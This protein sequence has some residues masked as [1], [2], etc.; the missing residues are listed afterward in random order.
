VKCSTNSIGI[1]Y[2][3]A[4]EV[5]DSVSS[6][7]AEGI[8]SQHRARAIVAVAI[9]VAMGS[10]GGLL[11]ADRPAAKTKAI[12]AAGQLQTASPAELIGRALAKRVE[13]QYRHLPLGKVAEDLQAR[14]GVPVVLD[15]RAIKD[16]GIGFDTPITFASSNV[17]TKAAIALMLRPLN[18]QAAVQHEVLL[19]TT[20]EEAETVIDV[21]VYEVSDLVCVDPSDSSQAEFDSLIDVITG[22][23]RPTSWPGS[24]PGPISTFAARGV[25]AIVVAQTQDVHEEIDL[26]LW[27]LRAARNASTKDRERA[28]RPKAKSLEGR[29]PSH[30]NVTE[31]TLLRTLRAEAAIR[32]SLAKPVQL[33]YAAMPLES[34]VDDLQVKV[35]IPIRLDRKALDDI[36]VGLDAPVTF[37]ASNISAKAAIALILRQLHLTA[38]TRYEVLLVT[39]PVEAATML[40][41]RVY[42]VSDL[43]SYYK[44]SDYRQPNV[45]SLIDLITSNILDSSWD[46]VGGPGSICP[47][48]APGLKA[49]VVSQTDRVHKDIEVLLSQLRAVCNAHAE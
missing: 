41:T 30:A 25:N 31:P 16:I 4:G 27:Q 43:L 18:L 46:R 10:G 39:T 28:D 48:Q 45:D 40:E 20:S 24:G 32:Q 2:N 13:L 38:I 17:S 49:I 33:R 5:L 26:L 6:F 9:I 7:P 35:G 36:G 42:E 21:M 12:Q 34:V 37:G 29:T 8:M 15:N 23:V 44:E 11:L 47:Y 14:L 1:G 3:R 19:I 22:S